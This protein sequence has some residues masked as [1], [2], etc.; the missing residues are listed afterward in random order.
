MKITRSFTKGLTLSML[1]LMGS[2]AGAAA[3]T[4]VVRNTNDSGAGSLRQ[5]I[6]NANANA[7]DDTINFDPAVVNV[8]RTITLTTGDLPITKDDIGGSGSNPGRLLTINGPGPDLLTISGNNA[9][10][11]FYLS[12]YSN[13]V[14]S[15]MTLRD[16]ISVGSDAGANEDG[17]AIHAQSSDLSLSNMVIRN[18]SA[19]SRG[20]GIPPEQSENDNHHRFRADGKFGDEQGR[21]NDRGAGSDQHHDEKCRRLEQLNRK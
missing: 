1:I 18:N 9:V 21:R 2:M 10:R 19:T 13:A 17:G 8:P 15:G 3:A 12:L 4:F 11:I 16:G 5:A 6:D 20:G 7:E 14:M